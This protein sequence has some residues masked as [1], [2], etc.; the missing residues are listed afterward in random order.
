VD[1]LWRAVTSGDASI[2]L[3]AFFPLA[4]YEQVKA[5]ANPAADWRSRLLAT[6][7][8]DIVGLHA[9]LGPQAPSARLLGVDVPDTAATRV[10][11]GAEFN[12]LSYWRV[13]R[14]AVRY[15]VGGR[16]ASFTVMSLISWRGQWYVVHLTTPPR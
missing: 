12:R 6:Y 4:A 15:E 14:T 1:Q 8:R 11:P 7:N 5:L 9:L 10:L 2:G 13:Y 3:P 16:A